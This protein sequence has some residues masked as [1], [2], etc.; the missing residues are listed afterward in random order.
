MA[1]SAINALANN[2]ITITETKHDALVRESEQLRILKNFVQL[3]EVIIKDSI[4]TLIK[5]MEGNR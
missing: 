5:A 3:D 2:T 1:V 4:I